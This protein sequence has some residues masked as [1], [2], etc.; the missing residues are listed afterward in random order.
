ML[1]K[2]FYINTLNSF[3][4]V[5]GEENEL[6]M[7]IE[8]MGEMT[9]VLCKYSRL[10]NS[11]NSLQNQ[12]LIEQTRNAIISATAD[13]II[14]TYQIARMFGLEKVRDVLNYKIIRCRKYINKTLNLTPVI[15]DNLDKNYFHETFELC[16][17]AWGEDAQIRMC[18]EEI[19]ELTKELCKFIRYSHEEKS[20]YYDN[21]IKQTIKN[22]I[23]E[24]ADVLICSGQMKL[25]FG[26]EQVIDKMDYSISIGKQIVE[27]HLNNADAN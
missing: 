15:P 11:T 13:V 10:V 6:R 24:T 1:D 22:I 17:K 14:Y 3:I 5:W 2:D 18:V 23:E 25:H 9:K 26:N 12:K 7:C 20:L 21:L 19:S 8:K 4:K 16:F 27:K